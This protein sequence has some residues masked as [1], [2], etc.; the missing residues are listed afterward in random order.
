[1]KLDEAL[2]DAETDVEAAGELQAAAPE[3]PDTEM[4]GKGNLNSGTDSLSN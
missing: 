4:P 3:M 1:M 2:E